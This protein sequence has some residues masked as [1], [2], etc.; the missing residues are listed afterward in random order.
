MMD[1]VLVAVIA[2]SHGIVMVKAMILEIKKHGHVL[3]S[4]QTTCIHMDTIVEL[5]RDQHIIM[6]HT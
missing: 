6:P 3:L 4:L 2:S 5:L 1:I